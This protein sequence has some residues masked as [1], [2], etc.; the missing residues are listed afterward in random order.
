M[1]M[2]QCSF[3]W[4]S[5]QDHVILKDISLR[6]SQGSLVAVVGRVGSGKSSLI[7]AILGEMTKISGQLNVDSSV[8]YVPQQPWM[9]NETLRNNILFGKDINP[10]VYSRVGIVHTL[11]SFPNETMHIFFF[12]VIDACALKPDLEIL[13]G[14]DQTEIGEKGIN[15]SGGQKQRISLARAVY[16]N[17]S[18]YLFDDPLSAVDS[19]VGKHLFQHVIGPK[20][21]LRKKTR[22]LVTHAINIL[23]KVDQIIVMSDGKISEIGTYEKLMK[24]K[25]DFAE[26]VFEQANQQ[27]GD[28]SGLS[29]SEKEE[30][31]FQL[32]ETFG[33]SKLDQMI[34]QQKERTRQKTRVKTSS[35]GSLSD[36]AESESEFDAMSTISANLMPMKDMAILSNQ[37][38]MVE[39]AKTSFVYETGKDLIEEETAQTHRVKF[40]IYLYYAKAIGALLS[41]TSIIFYALYQ[42]FN[43]AANM[44][45]AIWS[46]DAEA[47]TDISTRNL[48]LGIYGLFGL[49]QSFSILA[50]VLFI[51]VGTLRASI[52][53]HRQMLDHILGS[54]MAFFDTTPIGRIVNRFS[55]DIDEV[56]LMIPTHVKDILNNGF[57]V[58]GTLFIIAYATP[59]IIAFIIP[60]L[61]IFFIVQRSYLSISRQLK[62]MVS[63]TRSPINSSLTESFSGASTI[64]AFNMQEYFTAMNDDRIEINQMFYYPDCVCGSWL[65]CRLESMANVLIILASLLAV[66]Y[67]D[68]INPGLVGLS[69]TYAFTFQLDIFLLTRFIADL[70]KAIVSVER[71][72]EYQNTPLEAPA[73]IPGTDP[74]PEWP[75]NG[76]IVLNDYST[77]YRAG[78]DLVLR[79]LSVNIEP[80][81]K[82]GIVGRTGAGKSS[83]TLG[84]FRINEAAGGSIEVDGVNI[85][86]IGLFRLRSALT[87]IPQVSYLK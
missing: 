59:I 86:H 35:I 3:T 60:L 20:G 5:P 34:I 14:G 73:E 24:S 19:H 26:F 15:V 67:R 66:I 62:R 52:K 36:A 28:S 18:L 8:A 38:S 83:L 55:K 81:E 32:E 25:G 47:A 69:L 70:E 40:S 68:T 44:W 41:I 80:L 42:A 65:F 37:A 85:S 23:P 46:S 78:M 64:R 16:Q 45:L 7:S 82:V 58:I 71:I 84:L 10:V 79:N 56:D 30:L 4:G 72:K 31:K 6:V 1:V 22:I 63:V 27:T 49:L 13:G 12:Q 75:E 11:S 87:I 39:G 61:G 48:Y 53:L 9:Q 2:N 57:I 43:V 17:S 51:T 74:G 33:K 50:A 54:T 76:R 21:L 29:D 77:R